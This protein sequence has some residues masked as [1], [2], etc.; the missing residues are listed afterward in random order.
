VWQLGA[1]TAPIVLFGLP[2]GLLWFRGGPTAACRVPEQRPGGRSR[3]AHSRSTSHRDRRRR[4][5]DRAYAG[6]R[7]GRCFNGQRCARCSRRHHHDGA[8][9]MELGLPTGSDRRTDPNSRSRANVDHCSA[10]RDARAWRHVRGFDD[11]I[12]A[13]AADATGPAT[14][15]LTRAC[16]GRHQGELIS[17]LRTFDGCGEGAGH[18]CPPEV[19]PRAS[20][21][22]SSNQCGD[23]SG[24][25]GQASIRLGAPSQST[26]ARHLGARP[27]R[28]PRNASPFRKLSWISLARWTRRRSVSMHDR[29]SP[30]RAVGWI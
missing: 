29:T 13:C 27:R 3:Q 23:G 19:D 2:I 26:R 20:I 12:D 14:R 17:I 9:W 28:R 22:P 8:R 18:R 10:H 1:L 7:W 4:G 6:L 21:R 15:R 5:S 30:N 24:T 11:T 25:G 16:R